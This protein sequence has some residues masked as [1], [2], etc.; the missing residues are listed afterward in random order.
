MAKASPVFV[1]AG[2]GNNEPK[3]KST[4]ESIR[5]S[6]SIIFDTSDEETDTKKL[7]RDHLCVGYENKFDGPPPDGGVKA[8]TQALMAHF[9]VFNTWGTINSFGIFQTF[10]RDYLSRSASEISWI[11]SMQVFFLFVVGVFTGR[12]TDAG[13]FR[14]VF[15]SGSTLVVLGSLTASF[16]NQYWQLFLSQGLCVGLGMGGLFC[17][18]I[19]VLSTYFSRR[20]NLAIGVAIS[21]SA[22]GGMI[23]PIIAR[24]LLPMIGFSWTMRVMALIQLITLLIANF[25]MRSRIRPRRSGSVIEFSAFTEKAY[26]LFTIGM[27]FNFWGV[28]FAFYY[29]GP[30]SRDRLSFSYD[31]SINILIVMNGVGAIGRVIPGLLADLYLGP[32]NVM[33]PAAAICTTLLF[34]WIAIQ[35]STALYTWAVF[36]GIFGAT[37]QG[38]FPAALSSLTTDLQKAGTR[39]GMVYTIVS[40]ANL[41]GPPLAGL[42]IKAGEGRYVYAFIFGGLC[43][44]LGTSFLVASRIAKGGWGLAKV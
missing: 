17:P 38:L 10:Y 23:Y 19:A 3:D 15:A 40:F 24:Q 14:A 30:F 12:L 44:A 8:W 5:P 4:H 26:L 21:G 13:Y 36:Y 43:L 22:T 39:M 20:R 28:Y 18:V 1:T 33:I 6:R 42:L 11:G 31:S 37:V 29:I 32:L 34:C 41:T 25:S 35:S 16:S 7:A 9:V 27:F 2:S